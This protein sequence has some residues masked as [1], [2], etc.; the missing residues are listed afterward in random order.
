MAEGPGGNL[1]ISVVILFALLGL[2][3]IS[4]DRRPLVGWILLAVAGS[5]ANNIVRLDMEVWRPP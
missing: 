4:V 2:L 3:E 1:L 5:G